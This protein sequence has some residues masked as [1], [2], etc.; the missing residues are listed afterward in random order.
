MPRP[1]DNA[2][3]DPQEVTG[4]VPPTLDQVHALNQSKVES[5]DADA[6]ADDDAAD[7]DA[8][9]GDDDAA[10]GTSDDAGDSDSDADDDAA[11]DDDSDDDAAAGD[12]DAA[13]DLS[14]ATNDE[15]ETPDAPAE[16]PTKDT[17]IEKPGDGKVQIM[18]AA[19]KKFY[20]NDLD[21]IPEDFEPA[22][23]KE[24]MRGT[25]DLL[26]KEE[27]DVKAAEQATAD[28]EVAANKK[29]ANDMQDS[30]EAEASVLTTNG[31][32]PNEPAKLQAAKEEVYGYMESEL[33]KFNKTG[34]KEGGVYTSFT[35][36]YK[37]MKF[38]Q[39]EVARAKAAK[40][41]SDTKKKRAAMVQ[42]GGGGGGNP[43]GGNK[44]N[45][46]R[47]IE[48]PP[49]GAGLDAVHNHIKNTL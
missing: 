23:Y 8:N 32:F 17:D 49:Q 24:L 18:D 15:P 43:T 29:A 1:E 42:G 31:T 26:R 16:T 34:G 11:G 35:Q 2:Q 5:D 44:T 13:D 20:F 7:D 12:D 28:A 47:I 37:A 14:P 21:E 10:T 3:D 30:W 46:G 25:K 4:Q 41:T 38:D 6:P 36:A 27:S 22:S 39:A 9:T 40:D 45:R 19:G 33:Q 48:A